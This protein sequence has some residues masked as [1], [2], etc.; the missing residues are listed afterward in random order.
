MKNEPERKR[1]SDKGTES[2]KKQQ[3]ISEKSGSK[4]A[5]QHDFYHGDRV[6]AYSCGGS[7]FVSKLSKIE[8]T[9]LDMDKIEVN[10]DISQE[11]QKIM[12]GYQ[13]IAMFG[14]DNRS[15][16]NLSQGRSDVIMLANINNDTKEV[17]LVSVYRDTYL[18]TG[19]G[20]FQKCNA[21]YAKGGPEQAISMLNVNLDLNITDY[22]TVDFNSIIECVDLLGGVDME[23]TDDEASL[24]TG[25][26]RE[27][28]ELTGNKA[29]NLTQGGTYTLNG[30]QACAYARIRYGGGDDYR[31]TERQRTVLTAMVKKAQQ[32][33]LTTVNKLIN[34][35][36]GDIQTSFS[37]AELL[38]LASQVFQ[39]SIGDTTGFPFTKTTRV[40]SKKT[41]DVVIPCDLSDN[42]KELHI[43]LYEDSAYTASDTVKQNSEKIVSDTGFKSGDGH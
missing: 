42:V 28:N 16:G 25:Y 1:K 22:V 26:I 7:F 3:K 37:N 30:V 11:S 12:K 19:D 17:K 41:G 14:L 8:K 32:S 31:R 15:N 18:D 9:K 21:A 38:A 6:V 2:Q 23:I 39:Y 5:A 35:V 24:M 36:C 13:T 33:D 40:L 34:E 10:E 43:F 4:K 29:E 20:I 27:L